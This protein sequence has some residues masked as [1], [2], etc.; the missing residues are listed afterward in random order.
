M[1]IKA[2]YTLRETFTII[3]LTGRTGSGCTRFAEII[4]KP[5]KFENNPMLRTPGEIKYNKNLANN[6]VVF[7]RK[8]TICYNY[9]KTNHKEYQTIS[10]LSVL[11]LYSMHYGVHKKG[12]TS[13]N[14]FIDYIYDLVKENFKKSN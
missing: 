2:I 13:T 10:Y 7:K 4:S 8:Y 3:G 9:Y 5:P 1:S 6:N 11:L 12:K 14:D